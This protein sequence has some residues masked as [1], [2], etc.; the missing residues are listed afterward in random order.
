[1]E[2]T[3]SSRQWVAK[4]AKI[5]ENE[6]LASVL[7]R[8]MMVMNDISIINNEMFEWER[9]E[10]PKK[11]PRSR[12][13]I[14]YFGRVQSAHL[15]EALDIVYAI[16]YDGDLMKRVEQCEKQ[17]LENFNTVAVFL[18]SE[19]HKILAQLRNAVAFHYDP[20]LAMRR[21]KKLV[22][23]FPEHLS[24]YSMGSETLDWYYEL[25]DVIADGVLIRDVFKIK[26]EEDLAAAALEVLKRLHMI[27]EAYTNFAGYFIRECC[28]K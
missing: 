5:A 16:K 11:K 27:G 28:S 10:D 18:G 24:S 7:I 3:M 14:L 23:D 12:G 15:Y 19:D 22:A 9:T 4:T 6:K 20:K 21:L 25:G 2:E 26:E 8:L 13:A 1:V 17:V